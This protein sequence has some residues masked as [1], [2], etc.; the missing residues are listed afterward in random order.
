LWTIGRILEWSVG[1]FQK[2]GLRESPRLDAELLLCAV[3]NLKR[4][5]LYLRFEQ[6]LSAAELAQYKVLIK[7]RAE[8]EPV[9][10]LVGEQGFH[11]IVLKTDKRALIPRPET[12]LLVERAILQLPE[13]A[14]FVDIGTGT[15][16]ISLSILN[17][18][19]DVRA[20]ATDVSSEA[21][22]LAYENAKHLGLERQI[23]FLQGD[24]LSVV[25]ALK[26]D[27]VISNP[28][29]IAYQERSFV[30]DD[31]HLY[32]P[33][34]ALYAADNGLAMIRVLITG[35]CAFLKPCGFLLIEFGAFQKA[36]VES[37]VNAH[38]AEHHC[39]KTVQFYQD[40][41]LHDRV[42]EAHL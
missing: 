9:A 1:Y 2:H 21:L 22:S 35:A 17:A 39:F 19:R 30:Q 25:H 31:V 3:L 27:A 40:L 14:C 5:D 34:Q 28:P 24:A 18:R 8:Q 4:L 42:L 37:I 11:D 29:Y 6:P 26:F 12:E 33:H 15:G 32:E 41:N 20:V 38:C 16:A 7:R 10:Y 13:G 36:A 23:E